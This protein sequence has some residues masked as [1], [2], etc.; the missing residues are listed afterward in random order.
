MSTDDLSRLIASAARSLQRELGA[1]HTIDKVVELAVQLVGNAEHAGISLIRK[2]GSIDSPAA[3]DDVVRRADELQSEHQQGPC[4]DAILEQEVVDSPDIAADERWPVWGPRTTEETGLRSMMCFRLFTA[5]D[6]LGALN[7]YS[8][9]E[10]AFG[11]DDREVGQAL[12]AHA[13]LAV[14]AAQEIEAHDVAADNRTI[15]GQA[16]GILMERYDIDATRALAVLT[17]AS[18]QSHRGLRQTAYEVVTTR[19]TRQ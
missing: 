10:A 14:L 17:H 16:V 19:Q 12:A 8:D 3:S 6:A 18:Q 2:G 15:I 5:E 11:A 1:Q 9:R 13:A 7:L 4:V